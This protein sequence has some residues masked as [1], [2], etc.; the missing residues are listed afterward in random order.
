MAISSLGPVL[1]GCQESDCVPIPSKHVFISVH[2]VK[3]LDVASYF[4][5]ANRT[6]FSGLFAHKNIPAEVRRRKNE[7]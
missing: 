5:D 7:F 1:A 2:I 6:P 4:S 3:Y